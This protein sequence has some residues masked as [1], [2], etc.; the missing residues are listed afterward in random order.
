MT[1]LQDGVKLSLPNSLAGA[2]ALVDPPYAV[3]ED[4]PQSEE[5]SEEIK[6]D[7]QEIDDSL[8]EETPVDFEQ[9]V[10]AVDPPAVIEDGEGR[11][12][13][14]T[15][16]TVSVI[17]QNVTANTTTEA[18]YYEEVG[19]Y[20]EEIHVAIVINTKLIM[21]IACSYN[22]STWSTWLFTI[23]LCSSQPFS[24]C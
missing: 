14:E 6:I 18:D 17:A 11:T 12:T 10:K 15:V 21:I 1:I 23:D 16:T 19:E 3:N 9:P 13:N 2:A 4:P 8:R 24:Y 20:V 22:D 5:E 7:S